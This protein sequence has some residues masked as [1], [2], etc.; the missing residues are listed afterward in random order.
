MSYMLSGLPH[1]PRCK[2]LAQQI[3][4]LQTTLTELSKAP[5]SQPGYWDDLALTNLLY[6]VCLRYVAYPGEELIETPEEKAQVGAAITN[7]KVCSG[8]S[9]EEIGKEAEKAFKWAIDNGMKIELDHQLVY[10]ARE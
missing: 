5:S 6:G 2:L 1:A 10:C 3:P 4:S 8:N 9:P 7:G